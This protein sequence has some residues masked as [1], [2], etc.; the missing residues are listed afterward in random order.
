MWNQTIINK[1]RIDEGERKIMYCAGCGTELKSE[2]KICP[3]CGKAVEKQ[4]NLSEKSETKRGKKLSPKVIATIA[5]VAVLL[6]VLITRGNDAISDIKES[7]LP[8]YSEDLTIGEAF[9][10]F[11]VEPSWSTYESEDADVVVF[12]G[13]V[14]S[15]SDEKI[16]VTM[17][18][19]MYEESLEWQNVILYNVDMGTTTYLTD[20]E[21]ESLLNAIYENGTFSWVW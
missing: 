13:F 16:K 18:M 19:L 7:T 9:E 4:G 15:D 5:I 8:S 2:W 1:G 11:F 20:L 10:N 14:Y 21:L 17:E 6:L 3:T 12:N